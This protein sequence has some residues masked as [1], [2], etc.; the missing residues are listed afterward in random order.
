MKDTVVA[1]FVCSLLLAINA[2]ILICSEKKEHIRSAQEALLKDSH[3]ATFIVPS[4]RDNSLN[5]GHSMLFDY[6]QASML[7]N[8]RAMKQDVYTPNFK[9][10]K[11]S[12]YKRHRRR[13]WLYILLHPQC[14][15][16]PYLYTH[17]RN[18]RSLNN[19]KKVVK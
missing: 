10:V 9:D 15:R 6:L 7:F 3:R 2:F 4:Q 17:I 18:N 19:N 11:A 12:N 8:L 14:L 1:V 13:R 5:E 16:K